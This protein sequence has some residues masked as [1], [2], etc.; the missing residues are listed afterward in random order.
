MKKVELGSIKMSVLPNIDIV[1]CGIEERNASGEVGGIISKLLVLL[2]KITEIIIAAIARKMS[3]I[4][5]TSW[6][7]GMGWI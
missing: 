6:M 1:I 2:I 4:T 7:I 3:T 5:E